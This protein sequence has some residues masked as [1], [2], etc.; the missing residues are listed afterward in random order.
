MS[1]LTH[2]DR[3]YTPKAFYMFTA[4][5]LVSLAEEGKIK[6]D[7]P[8]G[9]YVRGL[10]PKLSQVNSQRILRMLETVPRSLTKRYEPIFTRLAVLKVSLCLA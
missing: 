6:L 3:F 9:K 5:L 4:A 8:I 7:V 2:D 1:S 10:G